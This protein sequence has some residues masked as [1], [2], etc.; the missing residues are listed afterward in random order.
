MQST[1]NTD[2]ISQAKPPGR[3]GDI[4]AYTNIKEGEKLLRTL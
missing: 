2:S 4:L 3:T 1:F